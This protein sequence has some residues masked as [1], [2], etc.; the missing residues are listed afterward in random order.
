M[1]KGIIYC[2]TNKINGKQYVGQT[3]DEQSR[4]SAFRT[5]ELY[6]TKLD[7]GGKLSKFD[8]A[9]KKYGIESFEYD[10][11]ETI[12]D[13]NLDN[14]HI[15][16]DLLEQKWIKILDTF[17]N[18]YNCTEGGFSGRLSEETKKKISESLKG[19]S[20]SELTYQKLCLTG[21]A[22][23]EESKK[24]ISEKAKERYKDPTNHP[25]YGKHHSEESK[26]KN[27]ESRKGKCKGSENKRSKPVLCFNKSGEFIKEFVCQGDALEWLGK[28]RQ[29]NSQI[30][31]CCN[32][33]VK[34]AFGY[35]W[36]F[37]ESEKS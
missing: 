10:I 37:K 12:E 27:S 6:C 28:D 36:K 21:Y 20:I 35:I 29:Y 30:S 24:K 32:K 25:M 19:H 34:T 14:L 9:R 2:Y 4:R 7:S 13:D 23:T 1:R 33:K 22:H 3:I 26:R 31:K 11:L 5:K 16:L 8:A 18:G 17:K 15:N